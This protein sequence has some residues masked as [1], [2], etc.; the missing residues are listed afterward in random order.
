MASIKHTKGSERKLIG[1]L[2][3]TKAGIYYPMTFPTADCQSVYISNGGQATPS[4]M[5]IGA[6]SWLPGH[7]PIYEGDTITIQF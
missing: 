6:L 7:T 2:G 3:E 1:V 5:T 4:H